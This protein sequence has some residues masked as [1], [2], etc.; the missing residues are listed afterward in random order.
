M[1]VANTI[2]RFALWRVTLSDLPIA[3]GV[4][5]FLWEE[6]AIFLPKLLPGYPKIRVPRQSLSVYTILDPMAF[7]YDTQCMCL[8]SEEL[9]ANVTIVYGQLF[10]L[11]H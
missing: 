4:R 2:S 11:F 6:L 9:I 1:R 7:S 3:Q 10:G 8:C 5:W